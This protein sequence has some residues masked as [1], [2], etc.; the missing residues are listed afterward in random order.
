[1]IIA[2]QTPN[3]MTGDGK[4]TSSGMILTEEAREVA[5]RAQRQDA[6][7]ITFDDLKS[8]ALDGRVSP[9]DLVWEPEMDNR[10]PAWQ[11]SGLSGP[12]PLPQEAEPPPS[13]ANH[14]QAEQHAA[15]SALFTFAPGATDLH[16]PHC[17][18]LIV[19]DSAPTR[20][21]K[22]HHEH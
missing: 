15:S 5:H 8:A 18:S 1:M 21:H 2:S 22:A 6:G 17:I 9:D 12:P 19:L 4:P 16:E 7:P 11:V 3:T 14:A 13:V 10:Q 20:G